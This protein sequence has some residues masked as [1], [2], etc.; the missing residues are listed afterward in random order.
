MKRILIPIALVA[1]LL[2]L[3]AISAHAQQT[4]VKKT[5][6]P[7]T[8]KATATTKATTTGK[9]TAST[10][11][12]AAGKAS[13]STIEQE[14]RTFSN[15]VDEKLEMQTAAVRLD[16]ATLQSDYARMTKRLD[17]ALDSLSTQSRREYLGQKARYKAW[18]L[19]QGHPVVE[20]PLV[21]EARDSAVNGVQRKLLNTT[22]PINRAMA[23][24][25]PDLYSRLV[26]STRTKHKTWTK[27]DWDDANLVLNRLNSRYEQVGEQLQ[28]E[29]RVRV[30]SLQAEFRTLEKARDLKGILNGF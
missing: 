25:L 19:E 24:A 11:A 14:L 8:G 17:S 6:S 20:A 29:D 3:A 27:E 10:K 12:T 13:A 21:G 2:P 26:E 15:W 30:R 7:A 18:A 28:I 9:A 16:W 4:T 5:T 23:S 1:L 22:A